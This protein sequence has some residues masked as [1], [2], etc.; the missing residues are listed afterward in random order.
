ML[1]CMVEARLSFVEH[2]TKRKE[3]QGTRNLEVD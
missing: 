3:K 1:L 2:P